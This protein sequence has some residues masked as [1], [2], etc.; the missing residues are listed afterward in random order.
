[1]AAPNY[2]LSGC[3]VIV[4]FVLVWTPVAAMFRNTWPPAIVRLALV[5]FLLAVGLIGWFLFVMICLR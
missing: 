3:F 1:M 5:P 4:P 2:L